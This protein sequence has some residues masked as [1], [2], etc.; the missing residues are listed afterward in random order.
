[1]ISYG[2]R[3]PL[4]GPSLEL[5][6]QMVVIQTTYPPVVP[7][8]LQMHI[9]TARIHIIV[10]MQMTMVHAIMLIPTVRIHIISQ[11]TTVRIMM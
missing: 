7:I 6:S 9:T 3:L 8:I 1:M 10:M 2:L 5:E 4:L 11:V